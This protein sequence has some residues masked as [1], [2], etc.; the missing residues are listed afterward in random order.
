MKLGIVEFQ[1]AHKGRIL[2]ACVRVG[3]TG[4]M[5]KF[6]NAVMRFVVVGVLYLVFIVGI[7]DYRMLLATILQ[8]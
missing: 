7:V 8:M 6:F 5:Q 1:A 3:L 4:F 2:F